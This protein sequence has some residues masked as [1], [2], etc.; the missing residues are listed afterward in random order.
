MLL[1][2]NVPVLRT[3]DPN[4]ESKLL[5]MAVTEYLKTPRY[6]VKKSSAHENPL[7]SASDED[8]LFLP[9]VTHMTSCD[10]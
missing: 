5:E 1:R 6:R 9:K 3:L 2:V 4:F 7:R 10:Q 8:D